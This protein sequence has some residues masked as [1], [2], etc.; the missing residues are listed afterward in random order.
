MW[1]SIAYCG[2]PPV[3]GALIGRFNLDPILIA[4]LISIALIHAGWRWRSA[5]S[6][7]VPLAGWAI[8]TAAL[9]SP[10]CA[11]SV[12][13]FSARVGQHMI[14]LLLAA[15]LVAM[16]L[17]GRGRGLWP[18]AVVFMILLWFWHM[19]GPYD[20]TLRST[21]LYWAMHLSLFGAGVWLWHTLIRHRDRDTPS[22]LAAGTA[23]S[24][25]MGLLG[26]VLTLGG[27][28]W[29]SVHYFSTQAWGLSPLADQQLGGVPMWVPGGVLFLWVAMRS[30]LVMWRSME[31]RQAA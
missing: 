31:G 14:L 4:S 6:V 19:P 16:A 15:P 23:T 30:L 21:Q 13:L 1:Q 10:L 2:T 24:M 26:A 27:H 20:A 22:V 29:F 8:A 9:I 12:A 11:L 28:P 3:P 17:P 18:A 5:Q 25:Q 7:G